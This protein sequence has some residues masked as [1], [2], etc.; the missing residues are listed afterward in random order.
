MKNF[1]EWNE[2]K[3]IINNSEILRTYKTRDVWWCS[4]GLNIGSEQD[5]KGFEYDRPVLILKVFNRQICLVIPLTTS[6]KQS[7]YLI[8]I[9]IFEGKNSMAIISQIRLIDTKRLVNKIG[10]LDVERFNIIRKAI[11]DYL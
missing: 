1:N 9:G 4:L 10:V 5:G 3:K 6:N 8:S 11:K 7:P 2:K